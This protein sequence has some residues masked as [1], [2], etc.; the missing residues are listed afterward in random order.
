MLLFALFS[1]KM[2]TL[3]II[4]VLVLSGVAQAG[5]FIAYLKMQDGKVLQLEI[6][7]I[8]ATPKSVF[9]FHFKNKN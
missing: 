9:F 3:I 6:P 8:P 2:K 7:S 1:G 4:G 5:A